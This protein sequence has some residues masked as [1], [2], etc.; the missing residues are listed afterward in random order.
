[1]VALAITM[2]I[3]STW[4]LGP[5]LVKFFAEMQRQQSR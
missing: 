4:I 3:G 1:M 2:K 5:S